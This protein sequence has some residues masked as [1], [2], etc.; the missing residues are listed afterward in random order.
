MVENMNVWD[1]L[2]GNSNE[3][4][5]S[6][7]EMND[8]IILDLG[9][10]KTVAGTTWINAMVRRW[11]KEG[12]YVKVVPER[13]SFRFGDGHVNQSRFAVIFHVKLATVPCLL[14]VS[15]VA[16]DCPPLLSKPVC[17]RLGL[18]VDTETH[19][20]VSKKYGVKAYGLEQSQGGHY[21]LKMEI[22][23]SRIP[24]HFNM[25]PHAEVQPLDDLGS[26]G[27]MPDTFVPASDSPRSSPLEVAH[28]GS[29]GMENA[30]NSSED[31]MDSGDIVVVGES[32]SPQKATR[33]VRLRHS[34]RATSL[35]KRTQESPPRTSRSSTQTAR[36]LQLK[37]SLASMQEQMEMMM[38]QMA[39][40]SSARSS[41]DLAM[42]QQMQQQPKEV[43][44]TVETKPASSNQ[45]VKNTSAKKPNKHA[46]LTGSEAPFPTLSNHFSHDLTFNI[47]RSLQSQV[48]TFKWKMMLLMM[49]VKVAV[50]ES[51]IRRK[52]RRN[53]RWILHTHGRFLASLWGHLGAARQLCFNP[54]LY[55]LALPAGETEDSFMLMWEK[56]EKDD[57][58]RRR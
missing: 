50:E 16:G 22:P 1:N 23:G 36:E 20:L 53:P 10:M 25:S 13:E 40:M 15:V 37:S 41:Q 42:L 51:D 33:K 4:C 38:Q 30:G 45:T 54:K 21:L 2:E 52:W 31:S 17:A 58:P 6:M 26:S 11:K 46:A 35:A 18:T 12:W 43:K 55:H 7:N 39:Q 8:K 27:A 29:V 48:V 49:R 3:V 34:K 24:S 47:M 9:C 57:K 56:K 14:R 44:E 5:W 19:T 28:G 32:S